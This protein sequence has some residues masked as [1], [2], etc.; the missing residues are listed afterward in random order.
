[1]QV[2]HCNWRGQGD[3]ERSDV[4]TDA[5]QS[6]SLRPPCCLRLSVIRRVVAPA[7]NVYIGANDDHESVMMLVNIHSHAQMIYTI[8]VTARMPSFPIV[9]LC[10]QPLGDS[11]QGLA[12]NV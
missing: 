11:I 9:C 2:F 7:L 5:P 12:F 3:S 6:S 10:A 8:S 4:T 1:M